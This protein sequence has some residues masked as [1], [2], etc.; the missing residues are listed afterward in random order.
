MGLTANVVPS[1][2]GR[3]RRPPGE[4][5]PLPRDP[6]WARWFWF[7]GA[8]LILGAIVGAAYAVAGAEIAEAEEGILEAFAELRS[9]VMNDLCRALAALS[10]AWALFGMRIAILVVLAILGHF[11][12]LVVALVAFAATDLI[13]TSLRVELPPPAVDVILQPALRGQEGYFFPSP[14]MTSLSVTL[15]AACYALVPAGRPRSRARI[16][17]GAV[18]L[19][20]VFARLVLGAGYPVPMLYGAVLGGTV[21]F[22]IFKW[23]APDA[24]FPVTMHR[25]GKAAH[26]DLTGPRAVAVRTAMR[27]QLGLEV[28]DLRPFGE[29]GSGGSTPLLMTLSDGTRVFGKILAISHVRSDRW[30]RIMRTIMYGQLEDEVPFGSVKRLIEYEDYALRVLDDFGFDVAHSY[31]IV[32]LTPNREYLLVEE[33]FEG[34]DTLGHAD[35]TDAVID[36]GIALVRKLWDE[37]LA[38]RDIKPANLLVVDGHLQLIDVSG[39]ELRP[40][41]WRQGVDLANMLLVLALRTDAERVYERAMRSFTPDE[42]AEALACAQGMA[43]PTELQGHLKADGRDLLSQLRALAPPHPPVS[44][45]R[46]SVQRLALT[47][48]AALG[49]IVAVSLAWNAL[50]AGLP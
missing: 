25:G 2:S 4:P 16:A 39:L 6:G 5:P 28:T 29:E 18:L 24:S 10:G 35:V 43:I 3:I 15:F 1:R 40:S 45:Q 44:I 12:H 17:A 38:H 42:I 21:A 11:R 34:A 23:L 14:A 50:V 33:F 46:W 27:E 30:Y 36:E 9:S 19:L 41:A 48:V 47:A 13:A 20:V 26:L 8:I 22:L 37:G 49:L 31:G 7:A 32:E